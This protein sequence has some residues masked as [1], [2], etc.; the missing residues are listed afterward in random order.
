MFYRLIVRGVPF[1]ILACWYFVPICASGQTQS[2][3][4]TS[5]QVQTSKTSDGKPMQ[6]HQI[7]PA[8][9][10]VLNRATDLFNKSDYKSAITEFQKAL[11]LDKN[12]VEI[13]SWIGS[14]YLRLINYSDA[15]AS[16]E[17]VV[18][19]DP[20]NASAHNNLGY[21]YIQL[22]DPA[23]AEG[24]YKQAIKLNPNFVDAHFNLGC[25][26][27]TQDKAKEAIEEFET[28]LKLDSTRSDCYIRIA[29]MALETKDF[30]KALLYLTKAQE[31]LAGKK[32]RASIEASS[33]IEVK[34]ALVEKGKGNKLGYKEKLEKALDIDPA[35]YEALLNLGIYFFEEKDETSCLSNLGEA[36]QR[37]PYDSA[38]HLWLGRYYFRL[39]DWKHA[40]KE[41]ES[42]IKCHPPKDKLQEYQ[43]WLDKAK[44][45]AGGQ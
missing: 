1:A 9:E 38:V 34:I 45:K 32:D 35:N 2:G 10:A 4:P 33:V 29:E 18:R 41:F 13:R 39:D 15:A 20:T 28:V 22:E 25:L 31:L 23:K 30:D 44:Q 12:N 17:D 21:C 27:Q 26:L 43:D 8:L 42:G 7:D 16:F 3:G 14:C 37:N 24:E 19:L 5:T 11:G 6:R 36:L 40:I